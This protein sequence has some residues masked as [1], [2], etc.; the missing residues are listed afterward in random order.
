[1]SDV[2]VG[3]KSIELQQKPQESRDPIELQREMQK[4][5]IRDLEWCILH[6][7]KRIDCSS[8]PNHH[9]CKGASAWT[10]S[11]Y[12]QVNCKAEKLLK[13]VIRNYFEPKRACPTPNYDQT[14]FFYNH[15]NDNIEFIWTIP[16]RETCQIYIENALQVVPE[17]KEL[18]NFILAFADGTL[19]KLAKKLNGERDDSPLLVN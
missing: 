12:V 17:E 6:A 4:D 8:I 15:E 9:V 19:Y 13:N 14:V 1:M 7:K 3:K 11:F 16:D 2:T 5:Y 18:L 10:G